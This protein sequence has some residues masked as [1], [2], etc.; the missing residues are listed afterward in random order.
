M[1]CDKFHTNIF[2][3]CFSWESQTQLTGNHLRNESNRSTGKMNKF[4]II[5]GKF[6][7][8][9]SHMRIDCSVQ[10]ILC[11]PVEAVRFAPERPLIQ[12]TAIN[13]ESISVSW[14][15][16]II[17]F[18]LLRSF[19]FS[20]FFV[21][22]RFMRFD[23]CKHYIVYDSRS[24]HA[25]NYEYTSTIIIITND[26]NNKTSFIDCDNSQRSTTKTSCTATI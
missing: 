1:F 20:F 17:R 23:V 25:L 19:Y 5:Y 22:F 9:A 15:M 16:N 4:C 3:E 12:L 2:G 26:N 24:T 8:N 7:F 18:F 21:Q 13:S 10:R 6:G 11:F 14:F